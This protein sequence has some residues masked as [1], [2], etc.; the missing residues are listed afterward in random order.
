MKIKHISQLALG[1]AL[2]FSACDATDLHPLDSLTDNSYWKTADD[3]QLYANGLLGNF[4]GAS[5]YGDDQSDVFVNQTVS[6]YLFDT[7][8]INSASGWDWGTIRS[9]NYFM[10]RY[11]Q[12]S[13]NEAE[14]NQYVGEVRFVRALQYY[15]KIRSFGDVPWYDK[16]LQTTDIEELY[17]PRDPRNMVLGKIIEDLEFAAKWCSTNKASGRPTADGALAQLARVCLY[18][19]TY[20]K[21]HNEPESNGLSSQILLQKAKAATDQLIASGKYDIVKAENPQGTETFPEW[22]LPYANLFVQDDLSGCAENIMARYYKENLVMHELGRQAGGKGF[23]LSKAFIESFLM[24]DGT[25]IYN[26]GSGY[27]GDNTIE[28]EIQGRDPRLWQIIATTR[29]PNWT[30]SGD[31]T[32]TPWG[33]SSTVNPDA[34]VT[35]YPCEKFHS[36]NF[37]QQQPNASTFDWFIYRY[38]EVLLINAEANY[39]LGSC[40]QAVLDAT[41][42]RLRDRVDMAHLTTAPVADAAP[43]DYGY[44]VDPLLYEIRRERCIE[45]INE[46]FRMDDLKRWNA[47][48]LLENPLTMLGMR[49]TDD[50]EAFFEPFSV[51]FGP[52]SRQTYTYNGK[53]YIQTYQP[54][55]MFSEG[56]KWTPNDRRWLSPIPLEQLRLNPNLKQNPGWENA[57]NQIEP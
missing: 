31:L 47:M 57:A 24:Q 13:G 20:M 7:Q 30:K 43:L 39:E 15:S 27:Q 11:Q 6:S 12:A 37:E 10:T 41:I 36:S 54:E 56:R 14:I 51:T 35:G 40:T 17:K 38:A 3:L 21:Y 29:R 23:G 25:P 34:G 16:D 45:L 53:T 1:C 26:A 8:T 18:Y 32:M 49:I 46:G 2:L 19:G 4:G 55:T 42:N 28:E 22:P 5:I 44:T 52:D 9:C 48:K 33:W 50:V